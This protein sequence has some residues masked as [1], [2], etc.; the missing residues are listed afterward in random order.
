MLRKLSLLACA[1]LFFGCHDMKDGHSHSMMQ[2]APKVATVMLAPS[3][4]ATTQ[5]SNNKVMGTV[6]FTEMGDHLH[7]TAHITGLAPNS[8]H[9]FH[10]H[11]KGDLSAPDLTSTGG[12]YNPDGHQHGAPGAMSHAG[13]LG[14]IT[15][16]ASGMAMVDMMLMGVTIGGAKND[17]IGKAVIVHGGTDDLTSQP[18]GA[19]GPRVA[20]GVIELK[21]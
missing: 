17:I 7:V 1:G 20:G 6:T 3:K 18:A 16:D 12:H 19:A 10:I 9:G 5:P 2:N 8:K 11:E 15:A 21:K 13:D 14:N 4:A